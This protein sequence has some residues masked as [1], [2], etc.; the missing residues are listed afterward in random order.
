MSQKIFFVSTHTLCFCLFFFQFLDEQNR[1]IVLFWDTLGSWRCFPCCNNEM[2]INLSSIV[3]PLGAKIITEDQPL[4]AGRRYNLG[5]VSWGSLPAAEIS[6]YRRTS[7]SSKGIIPM[8]INPEDTETTVS[9][10]NNI[11]ESRIV[12]TP[13]PMHHQQI[14]TCRATNYKLQGANN[15]MEDHRT[16]DIFCKENHC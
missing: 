7:S 9:R 2:H 16:L 13:S 1:R 8:S 10:N 15:V 11:T 5:C 12:F 14:I 3:P 4:V 6:W